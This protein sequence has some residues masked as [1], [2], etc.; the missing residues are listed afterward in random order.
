MCLCMYMLFHPEGTSFSLL[1]KSFPSQHFL[2]TSPT[3]ENISVVREAFKLPPQT[4][5]G[6]KRIHLDVPTL[7]LLCS[8]SLSDWPRF[9]S[10]HRGATSLTRVGKILAKASVFAS[11]DGEIFPKDRFTLYWLVSPSEETPDTK[12]RSLPNLFDCALFI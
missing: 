11:V 6:W 4:I 9:V 8:S 12:R 3:N 5:H 1:A 10:S 7:F 2:E